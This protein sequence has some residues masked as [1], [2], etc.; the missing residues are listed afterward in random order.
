M[1]IHLTLMD[2]LYALV[3]HTVHAYIPAY[4]QVNTVSVKVWHMR[5][6]KTFHMVV[7][8]LPYDPTR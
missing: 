2:G 4:T 8:Y 7:E 1:H 5:F 3:V 6:V